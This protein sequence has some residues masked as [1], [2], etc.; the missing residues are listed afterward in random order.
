MVLRSSILILIFFSVFCELLFSQG[1]PVETP[2]DTVHGQNDSI[3][4]YPVAESEITDI[5][6]YI[7]SD[8]AVFDLKSNQLFLYNKAEL[9]YQDMR[10]TA[11]KIVIDRQTQ[12]LDAT[13]VADSTN[14][15]GFSQL[16]V[17][18]QGSEVYEGSHLTYNFKTRQGSVS[19]G[20]TEADVGIT[21]A[22]KSNALPATFTTSKVDFTLLPP[23]GLIPNTF[24]VPP[25]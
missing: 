11:G 21:S 6:N 1:N 8:S 4:E 24:S 13:G 2:A 9:T 18:I 23:I 14:E 17:M 7:A 16:P 19:Q 3:H 5:I 15:S 20:F 22:I 10:L 12:I 25:K